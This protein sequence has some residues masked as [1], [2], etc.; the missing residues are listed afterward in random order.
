MGISCR[1]AAIVA[2]RWT[3]TI[4]RLNARSGRVARRHVRDFKAAISLGLP[5]WQVEFSDMIAC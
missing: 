3:R 5:F 1:T 2:G 4:L